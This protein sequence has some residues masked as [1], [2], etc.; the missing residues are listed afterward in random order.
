MKNMYKRRKTHVYKWEGG[1]WIQPVF[2]VFAEKA[3][4]FA[5]GRATLHFHCV[6]GAKNTGP[7]PAQK[8]EQV[9]R[10]VETRFRQRE[11]S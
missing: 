7:P 4:C 2:K 3:V 10:S 11:K 8:A 5:P 1:C 6:S 9:H